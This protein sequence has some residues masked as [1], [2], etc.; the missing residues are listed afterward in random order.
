M[1]VVATVVAGDSLLARFYESIRI[2]AIL[3]NRAHV[4]FLLAQRPVFS[5][6][7]WGKSQTA[8]DVVSPFCG[9]DDD[10]GSMRWNTIR[11][12]PDRMGVRSVEY[13][14]CEF[15]NHLEYRLHRAGVQHFGIPLD[16]CVDRLEFR[17]GATVRRKI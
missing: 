9:D 16:T 3:I 15:D 13:S 1:V 12:G 4:I 8:M 7:A 2:R 6:F 11:N 5:F 17:F 14:K 10:C